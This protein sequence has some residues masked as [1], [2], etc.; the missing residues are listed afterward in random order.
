MNPQLETLSILAGVVAIPVAIVAAF[1]FLL[2]KHR[3]LSAAMHEHLD[4]YAVVM[5]AQAG[6]NANL[7]EAVTYQHDGLHEQREAVDAHTRT[8]KGQSAVLEVLTRTVN[9]HTL[10]FESLVG[11]VSRLQDI[12]HSAIEAASAAQR[13]YGR[14]LEREGFSEDELKALGK[15]LAKWQH[16]GR[17]N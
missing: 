2:W 13:F 3:R 15:A 14:A 11:E 5:H 12:T 10:H 9:Q 17:L 7:R 4:N 1:A 16:A 6:I 8:G